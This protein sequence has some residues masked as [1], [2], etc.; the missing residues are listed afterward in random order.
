MKN[1]LII[2]DSCKKN[3]ENHVN[4]FTSRKDI[5]MIHS[6]ENEYLK[7]IN[8]RLTCL[9]MLASKILHESFNDLLMFE[10]VNHDLNSEFHNQPERLSEKT[11]DMDKQY[12]DDLNQILEL[13]DLIRDNCSPKDRIYKEMSLIRPFMLDI[14]NKYCRSDEGCDSLNS[15][16]KVER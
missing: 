10:W 16:D 7:Q 4:S 2:C 8:I 13:F 14:K 15:T 1:N 6:C 3:L 12:I 9:E 5:S 11:L